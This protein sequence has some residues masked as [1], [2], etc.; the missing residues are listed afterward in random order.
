MLD[1]ILSPEDPALNKTDQAPSALKQIHSKAKEEPSKGS[2]S[3]H[4]K[5]IFIFVLNF[6][7][8]LKIVFL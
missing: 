4:S 6:I 1:T 5:S 2:F 8:F 7:F 3:F